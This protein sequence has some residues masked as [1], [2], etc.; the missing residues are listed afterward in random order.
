MKKDLV[1]K[2]IKNVRKIST[3]TM[4]SVHCAN[5]FE[6]QFFGF[7]KV[8]ESSLNALRLQWYEKTSHSP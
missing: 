8:K 2:Y 6:R 5:P 7:V 4:Y 3:C 1:K